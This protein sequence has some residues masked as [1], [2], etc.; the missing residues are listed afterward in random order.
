MKLNTI[1]AFEYYG[2]E[3][4]IL[5]DENELYAVDIRADNYDGAFIG[6]YLDI[7]TRQNAER[8]GKAFIDGLLT[9]KGPK[10]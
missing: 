8:M 10:S 3:I 4:I 1:D 9:D 6:G 2:H 7:D 5:Q